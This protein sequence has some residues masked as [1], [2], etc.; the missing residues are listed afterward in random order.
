MEGT[1]YAILATIVSW[2]PKHLRQANNIVYYGPQFSVP[3]KHALKVTLMI[4]SVFL[5]P[6][7]LSSEQLARIWGLGEF[8]AFAGEAEYIGHGFFALT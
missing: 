2:G 7:G 6:L 1:Q 8:F 3:Y 4:K 5:L